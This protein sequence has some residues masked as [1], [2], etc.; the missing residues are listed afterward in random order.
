[1]NR[2]LDVAFPTA[3]GAGGGVLAV[4]ENY[5]LLLGKITFAGMCEI[6]LQAAVFAIVGGVIGYVV[7]KLM[8]ELFKKKT[9]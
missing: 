9:E 4:I 2:F 5:T 1:M 7:K 6:A 3:G 8:D